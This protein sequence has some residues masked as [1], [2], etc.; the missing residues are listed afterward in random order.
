MFS[1]SC[2]TSR[3]FQGVLLDTMCDII[4]M[5]KKEKQRKFSNDKR[6]E[7]MDNLK[8]CWHCLLAI[9]SREGTQ[10]TIPLNIDP[11]DPDI[12][13]DW[14]KETADEAGFDVLY[15]IIG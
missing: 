6:V 14:C 8:V 11:E 1:A 13:C 2:Q 9:E 4:L 10:A 3:M 5:S 15:E 12:R 7:V